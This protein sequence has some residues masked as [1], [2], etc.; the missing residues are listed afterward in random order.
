M[1][2]R[3]VLRSPTN[4][5]GDKFNPTWVYSL[6]SQV[7]DGGLIAERVAQGWSIQLDNVPG[8]NQN[9]DVFVLLGRPG[10]NE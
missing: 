10:E 4:L 7:H 5:L 8:G 2:A 6:L 3:A 9:G 1:D